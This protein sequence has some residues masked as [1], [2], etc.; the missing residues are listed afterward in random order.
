MDEKLTEEQLQE[1][2][3]LGFLTDLSMR[4]KQ[5]KKNIQDLIDNST[6]ESDENN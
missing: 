1:Q 6:D 4:V 2:K 5:T 3:A